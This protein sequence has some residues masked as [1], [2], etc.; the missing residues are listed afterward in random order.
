VRLAWDTPGERFYEQGVDRGVLYVGGQGYA[1][2]GLVSVSESIQGGQAKPYYIDG[3]KYSNLSSAE[4]FAATIEAFSAPA[5]FAPCDGYAL[6]Q[7]GLIATNQRRRSFDFSYRTLVGNDVK[8][9][10]YGYKIH[11][12]YKALAAPSNA[13]YSTLGQNNTPNTLSWG[14]TTLPPLASGFRPTSHFIIDSQTT[15]PDILAQIE[16]ILYGDDDS[17]AMIPTVPALI[18]IF[19]GTVSEFDAGDVDTTGIDFLDGG[20]A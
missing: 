7:N 19:G 20:T 9:L 10:Q 3:I 6:I 12:V 13:K 4:E 17:D 14:I 15:D 11:L 16:G 1:W 8:Q 18:T 2:S 5:E